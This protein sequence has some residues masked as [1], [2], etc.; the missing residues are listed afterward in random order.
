M[1]KFFQSLISSILA[2][3]ILF[4][5]AF[6]A[7]PNEDILD[8]FDQNGIYY[9]NPDGNLD[10]CGGG[11]TTLPGDTVAEKIWNYMIQKGYNDAQAAGVV[12]NAEAESGLNPTR[13][14]DNDYWGLFQLMHTAQRDAMWAQIS[15]EGYGEYL[16]PSY[17]PAGAVDRIPPDAVDALVRIIMDYTFDPNDT[18]WQTEL[19]NATTPEE[20][21]EIFLVHYERAFG[22]NSTIQYYSPYVGRLYQAADRRREFARKWFDEFSGHGIVGSASSESDGSNVTI[23]GDSI[24]VGATNALKNVFT[25]IT[26]A[27][28]DARV[29]RPWAEGKN[30]AK[31]MN[32]KNVVVFALGTNNDPLTQNDID[33]AI[34]IIG[35][36]RLI[37]FVTNY[38][39]GAKNGYPE[40][41]NELLKKAAAEN[42]NVVVADWYEAIK[43]NPEQYLANDLLHPN[44]AGAEL[45]A[46]TIY[47]AVNSNAS[48]FGC[49]VSGDFEK[50][51]LSYAWPEYH[52]ASFTERRPEYISAVNQ[53]VS[54]GR[55][56]GGFEGVDC[57][58]FVTILVQ[59]SG[60]EPDYNKTAPGPGPTS[61]QEPWV[62]QHGWVLLNSDPNTPVDAS[63]LQAGDVAF[64]NGHTFIYVGEINGF[65]ST[66]ASASFGERAPMAGKEA[67]DFGNGVVV[68]WYRNPSYTTGHSASS[69]INSKISGD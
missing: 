17:W 33:G 63:I 19:K 58:G 22:G 24:T 55:Y 5:P 21:A 66:I 2:V 64:S 11:A 16:D 6:A 59:N 13:R 26:D 53:S 45:F 39:G 10:A 38:N 60:L 50:L 30:V 43:N 69:N 62:Q 29:A 54:E 35:S 8:F 48:N 27:D 65:D 36:N 20:A 9:Y 7:I 32:L 52:P 68:R 15:A 47:D 44:A 18:M 42:S 23:I 12:G 3:I 14:G 40:S 51:V 28:I 46:Q 67:T 49:T 1:K 61:A 57:G 37:V 31:T 25:G 4:Q 34:S 56:V 41:N